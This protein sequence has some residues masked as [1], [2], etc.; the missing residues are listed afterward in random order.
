MGLRYT[1]FIK[2]KEVIKDTKGE[3]KEIRVER[4]TPKTPEELE[5]MKKIKGRIHWISEKD[6]INCEARL[7]EPLF[8]VDNPN[9]VE[10]FLDV[11]DRDSLKV[12]NNIKFNKKL[13]PSNSLKMIRSNT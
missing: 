2:C 6:A 4:I 8:T 11:V 3:I 9:E 7:Y 10:D 1:D 12:L 13:L 5:E